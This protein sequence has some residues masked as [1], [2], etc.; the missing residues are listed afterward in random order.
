MKFLVIIF[1]ALLLS[2]CASTIDTYNP[3]NLTSQTLS[4][5][6]VDDVGLWVG[7]YEL[8]TDIASAFDTN[9]AKVISV[10]FWDTVP[11]VVYLKEGQYQFVIRCESR[12]LYNFHHIDTT[13]AKGQKYKAY[14]LGKYEDA[15]LGD[16]LTNIFGFISEEDDL[17]AEKVT[18]QKIIDSL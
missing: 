5:V 16:R 4:S 6:S 10:N 2:A 8:V 3:D 9:G 13:L 1:S 11:A 12:G 15:F 7:D 17:L 18:N 14:C